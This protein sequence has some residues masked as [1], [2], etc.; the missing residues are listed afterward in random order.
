[1]INQNIDKIKSVA[2]RAVRAFI[3]G[4]LASAVAMPI[5]GVATWTDLFTSLQTV[6]LA[7]TVGGIGA[8]IMALDKYF[9]S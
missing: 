4:F 9:R 6:A 2:M 8:V 3:A 5:M 7:G 1:M